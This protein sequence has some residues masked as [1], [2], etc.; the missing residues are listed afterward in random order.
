VSGASGEPTDASGQSQEDVDTKLGV[1]LSDSVE[2]SHRN[3]RLLLPL[4]ISLAFDITLSVLLGIAL[5]RTDNAQRDSHR[6]AKST[7][8]TFNTTRAGELALWEP[9]LSAPRAP[10]PATAT[11]AERQAYDDATKARVQFETNLHRYFDPIPC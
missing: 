9:I 11:D 2:L 7:C 4:A 5:I 6:L 3:W 8:E 10:L 1:L